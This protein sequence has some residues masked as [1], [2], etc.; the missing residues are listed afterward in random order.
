ML[1]PPRAQTF[2][3]DSATAVPH[4]SPARRWLIVCATIL[5]CTLWPCAGVYTDSEP[6]DFKGK[7]DPFKVLGLPLS[8]KLPAKNVLKKAFKKAALKWHP[9]RC[10]RTMPEKKCKDKMLDV[11]L[12]NDVLSDR[13][14]F[15]QWEGWDED[16]RLGRKRGHRAGGAGGFPGGFGGGGGGFP[17]GGGFDFD[18]SSMFGGGGPQ[19]GRA[20]QS[21]P[22]PKKRPSTSPRPPPSPPKKPPVDEKE[23]TVVSRQKSQGVGGAQVELITRERDLK[24]TPS[25]QVEILERTCYEAQVQCQ[26]QVLERRRRRKDSNAKKSEL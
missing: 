21:R 15:Q 19:P 25:I 23:W 3:A 6:I 22:K 26:D 20:Q 8:Q 10:T 18:F 11:T 13:R 24:G 16:R 17:G 1:S 7:F 2:W 9:D 14:K 12:A 5:G 4:R